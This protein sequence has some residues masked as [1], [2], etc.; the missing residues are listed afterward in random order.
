MSCC[1]GGRVLLLLLVVE[2]PPVE[3]DVRLRAV[4]RVVHP[5]PALLHPDRP[6]LVLVRPSQPT[7]SVFESLLKGFEGAEMILMKP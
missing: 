4:D 1:G 7:Q 6:P 2:R 5:S 3:H